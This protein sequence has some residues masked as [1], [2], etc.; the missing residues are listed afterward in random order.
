VTCTNECSLNSSIA[1][2]FPNES[3]KC[4][5]HLSKTNFQRRQFDPRRL[6]FDNLCLPKMKKSQGEK[7]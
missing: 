7:A 2:P 1:R 6:M 3:A 4:K 5:I